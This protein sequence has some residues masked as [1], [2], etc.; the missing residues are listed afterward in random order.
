MKKERRKR[1]N[2]NPQYLRT[3]AMAL[4]LIQ[5]TLQLKILQIRRYCKWTSDNKF[6]NLDG[7]D[8]FK[9]PNTKNPFTTINREEKK[10]AKI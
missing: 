3:K 1:E 2:I 10:S 8:K 9:I 6:N 7:L 4:L 5:Q